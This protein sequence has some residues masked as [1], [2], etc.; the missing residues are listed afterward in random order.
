M[1]IRSLAQKPPMGWNNFDCYGCAANER[2]LL[3]NLEVFAERLKPYGYE[4][5]RPR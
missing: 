1:K 3:A 5:I 4:V 2:V